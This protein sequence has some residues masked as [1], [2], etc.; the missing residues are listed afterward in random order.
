MESTHILQ[1]LLVDFMLLLM[2][3]IL[4][5]FETIFIEGICWHESLSSNSMFA[6]R[7]Q[8][9]VY[10]CLHQCMVS[11]GYFKYTNVN[12][13]N[14]LIGVSLGYSSFCFHF[15]LSRGCIFQTHSLTWWGHSDCKIEFL[16]IFG[17]YFFRM[18]SWINFASIFGSQNWNQKRRQS[19][20]KMDAKL[21]PEPDRFWDGCSDAILIPKW[22]PE[23]LPTCQT[24]RRNRSK[25]ASVLKNE[26]FWKFGILENYWKSME[27]G[28]QKW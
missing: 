28:S 14:C 9:H 4:P 2:L 18:N 5:T 26:V 3:A 7:A 22:F 10:K 11:L 15:S 1:L 19:G 25:T 17:Q 6:D 20:G 12:W 13:I 24:S 23:W 27:P 21:D 16:G 8:G